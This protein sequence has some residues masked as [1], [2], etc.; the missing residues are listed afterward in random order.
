[1]EVNLENSIR[2]FLI[3]NFLFGEDTGLAA[4]ASFIEN[5]VIDSTGVLDLI[6]FIEGTFG[7]K[8]KDN[9]IVPENFDSI[10]NVCLFLDRK[11]SECSAAGYAGQAEAAQPA[12]LPS[13]TPSID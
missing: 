7:I 11:L 6:A 2:M 13:D 10:R 12:V 1:V 8:V 3:D 5:G 4:D 9:E